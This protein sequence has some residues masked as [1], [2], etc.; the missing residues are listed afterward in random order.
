MKMTVDLPASLVRELKLKAARENRKL[1]DIVREGMEQSLEAKPL[2]V[3]RSTGSKADSPLMIDEQGF[4]IFRCHP[5]APATR[6]TGAELLALE[7]EALLE[8]DLKRA[9]IID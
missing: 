3:A 4:P 1:K 5:N 7:Q 2:A 9:G 6:M 8:E